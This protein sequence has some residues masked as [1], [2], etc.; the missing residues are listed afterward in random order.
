MTAFGRMASGQ[1]FHCLVVGKQ[2]DGSGI[3]DPAL[4]PFI[5]AVEA[6]TA[7]L[8]KWRR[9][10]VIACQ[11]GA[12]ETGADCQGV[13]G[14]NPHFVGFENPH[15]LVIA[16]GNAFQPDMREKVDHHATCLQAGFRQSFDAQRKRAKGALS[17]RSSI[18]II[19]RAT[20]VFIR[21]E[22]VVI[23]RRQRTV[24]ET[25]VLGTDMTKAVPLGRKLQADQR[26]V[27][28]HR[29]AL[30]R[31]CTI[32]RIIHR[33]VFAAQEIAKFGRLAAR[34]QFDVPRAIEWQRQAK[35]Q[36]FSHFRSGGLAAFRGD[37]V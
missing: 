35:R 28:A 4:Q 27:I 10:I 17:R 2:R 36:P 26:L 29:I 33:R 31:Q 11:Q 9:R 25:V 37:Q 21:L 14:F 18:Q 12:I 8:I 6:S 20:D 19:E 15:Q 34:V 5:T 22:P 1:Q 7:V 13:A 3:G 24:A 16:N 30:P 23:G 32:N